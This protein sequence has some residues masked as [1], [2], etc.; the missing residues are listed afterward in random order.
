[1]PRQLGTGRLL[2][3]AWASAPALNVFTQNAAPADAVPFAARV[4]DV[5]YVYS[6]NSVAHHRILCDVF[7][8]LK[9][10][11]V[12]SDLFHVEVRVSDTIIDGHSLKGETAF[13]C[14]SAHVR[15]HAL[16]GRC[17]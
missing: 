5:G 3:W 14:L 9:P 7:K 17:L 13:C 11:D 1:M 2:C 6:D 16:N 4:Q 15:M 10:A 8:G 12:K